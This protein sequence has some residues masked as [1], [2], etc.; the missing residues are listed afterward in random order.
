[1]LLARMG[2]LDTRTRVC[3]KV[4]PHHV[5]CI[6]I[7]IGSGSLLDKPIIET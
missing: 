4:A 5:V 2:I 6:T 3:M 7:T 1:L